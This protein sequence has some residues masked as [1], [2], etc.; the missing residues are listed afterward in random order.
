M[1]KQ[2]LE[3]A[4]QA[5]LH[6]KSVFP[7]S[8]DDPTGWNYEYHKKFAELIV[9]ECMTMCDNVSADYFKH[10]KAADDFRDKNIYAEGE[11]ACDEV[12]YEIK[13]HFGVDDNPVE[14]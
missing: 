13:K 14:E 1:N 8:I 6:A 3:Y 10:R 11:S 2:I 5:R 7:N 9:Q 12:R 4:E